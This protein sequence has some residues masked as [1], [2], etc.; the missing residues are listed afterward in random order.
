M[1]SENQIIVRC[2]QPIKKPLQCS[3]PFSYS[4]FF[5]LFCCHFFSFY[6]L[7]ALHSDANS[8]TVYVLGY[9][10][11][12]GLLGA[13]LNPRLTARAKMSL[14]RAQNIFMPANIN[15]SVLMVHD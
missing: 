6:F 5:R 14:R 3:K 2:K 10:Y 1:K 13:H 8:N 9:K 4:L 7:N 15:P 11:I 12:L